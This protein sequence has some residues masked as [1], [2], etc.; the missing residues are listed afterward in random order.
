MAIYYPPTANGIQKT[1]GAQLD[2]GFTS[3]ATLNNTT[4]IQNLKG[5]FVVDRIDTSGAEKN[6]SLREYISFAGTSGSTVT[7]LVRGLGGTTDQDHAIGAVV[8][9]VNDIVQQQAILDT[10]TAEHS[11]AGVHD[12]TKVAMLAGAQT[13]TGA[14]TFTTGLL[15]AVD[16]TSGAG[17]STLPTSS[18]TLVGRATTDTLTNKRKQPRV[19]TTTSIAGTP[20]VLTPEISTYDNFEITAQAAALDIANHSTSTPTQGE[21]MVIAITSDATPRALTYG[22]NYVAKGGTALP[23]TT[24]ASKTTTL[25]F[26]WNAGL[27][28]WNLL[29]VG[30]EA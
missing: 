23:T 15:K 16:I 7:T 1:L 30:Q 12:A 11:T 10:I 18:D 17:V 20:G 13:V 5:L 25:G 14:K 29:A 8:E 4:N 6:A 24:V 26:M 21:T 3:S 28:K 9:F 22:T 2:I 27:G 19:Y